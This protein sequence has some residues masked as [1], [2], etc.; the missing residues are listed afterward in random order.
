MS[1][2]K[3]NQVKSLT[4]DVKNAGN[5]MTR[6]KGKGKNCKTNSPRGSDYSIFADANQGH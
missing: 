2:V 3:Q 5:K 4:D 6:A 1:Y